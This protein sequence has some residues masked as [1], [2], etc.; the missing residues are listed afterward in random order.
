MTA[1]APGTPCPAPW[2]GSPWW[3]V[4][5]CARCGPGARRPRT[6]PRARS[7]TRRRPSRRS[8]AW[9][10]WA[11]WPWP[12]SCRGW[13]PTSRRPSSPTGWG[14]APTAGAASGLRRAAGVEHRHR[15]RPRQPVDRPGV[16][17]PQH[18]RP[19]RAAAGRH[20]R[21]LPPRS[22]AVQRRLHLR[23][24][25][26]SDPRADRRARGAAPRRADLGARQRDR[27]APGRTAGRRR[28]EPLRGRRVEHD[29]AG[30]SCSSP[31]RP[32]YTTEFVELDPEDAQFSADLDNPQI[33]GNE[34]AGRPARATEVRSVLD[35]ITDDGDS[36]LQVARKIQA[37]L[38]GSQFT[39]SLQLAEQ[40]ADGDLSD[41]P[42]ARFL[43][44]K[45]GYCVQFT[46]AMVMLAREAGIPARMAVGFLPGV[47]RRRRPRRA[48]LRRPRVA[49]AV[50]PAAGLGALGADPGHAQRRRPG[51]QPGAHR[52]RLVVERQPDLV[53]LDVVGRRPR[54]RRRETSPPTPPASRVGAP[55]AAR[56]ASSPGTPRPSSSCCSSCSSRRSSLRCLAGA[57][58]GPP[59]GP[60][61]RRPGRGRVAV[62]AAA[63]A[64]H[65]FRPAR[66]GH[67][68]A[69][70]TPD[71]P[72]RLPL[73]RRERG[74]RPGRRHAGAGPVRPA[75][76]PTW[77][78][79]ATTR[80]P[81]GEAPCPV[82]GAPTGSGRCCCPRRAS[83]C[84]ARSDAACSS[85]VGPRST[86]A[87]RT[88]DP[89]VA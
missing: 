19:A 68:A 85:G 15:P 71:R 27:R 9:S 64:G 21:Q 31:R 40:A 5:G 35:Q 78:T 77:S 24:G 16:P 46:S 12:S 6:R 10:A 4:R 69:D 83:R 20:P 82:D 59:H 38:R 76:A 53:D 60:R 80:A 47:D 8:A 2:P 52:H 39:Y 63:V 44:T 18:V 55:A 73:H 22:V 89:A 58:A 29:R 34:L 86:R 87:R 70:V 42:L 13:C 62:A 84:G 49:R 66:R 25:R 79:S 11:P 48:R 45:R 57:A 33:D 72:R 65:R 51:V 88:S 61:R 36:A 74:P 32:S 81:S 54:A 56:C 7:P 37:Y 50:L 23:P 43:E 3:G 75:R 28:R 1:W 14:A 30:A 67:A 17:L 26:R 41:E